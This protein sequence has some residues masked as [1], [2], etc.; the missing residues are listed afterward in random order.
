MGI[1]A[2]LQNWYVTA[3]VPDPSLSLRSLSSTNAF[4]SVRLLLAILLAA[5]LPLLCPCCAA[6]H[7][8]LH[9]VLCAARGGQHGE[10]RY[11]MGLLKVEGV[12]GRYNMC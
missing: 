11:V 5:A 6:C 1:A 9:L 7:C 12:P 3:P 4:L 8:E 10:A 2:S